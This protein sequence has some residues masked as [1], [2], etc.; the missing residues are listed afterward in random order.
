MK[1][2][3]Q[4]LQRKVHIMVV[5]FFLI[6]IDGNLCFEFRFVHLKSMHQSGKGIDICH[7]EVW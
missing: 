6:T 3:A 7:G 4:S 5:F 2:I 1:Y